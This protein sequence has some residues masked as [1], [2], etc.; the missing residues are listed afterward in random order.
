VADVA[1]ADLQAGMLVVNP[2]WDLGQPEVLQVLGVSVP[3]TDGMVVITASGGTAMVAGDWPVEM[4][5]AERQAL[6]E[7]LI[8]MERSCAP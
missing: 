6:E 2:V 4:Y 7:M 5:T 8:A 3:D 1:A